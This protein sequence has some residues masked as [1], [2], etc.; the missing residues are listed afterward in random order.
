VR[1][2]FV[3]APS[4]MFESWMWQPA[5]LHNVSAHLRTGD[6]LPDAMVRALIERRKTSSGAFWTRQALLGIY[7][8][9]LHGSPAIPDATALWFDLSRK[10]TAV[11]P[12]PGTFPEAAFIFLMGGYDAGYYGYLW[13][14][15]HALD[16][17]SAVVRAGLEDRETGM[18]FRREV[19]EPGATIEPEEL[20]RSFL[21]RA[22]S[23]EAFY[24]ELGM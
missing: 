14:K 19:L 10:L 4:Q 20:I 1:R 15:V 16:M 9:S 13:S 8:L 12:A 11:P 24:A 3:E 22:P 17:F 2:D 23:A 6:P 18:R 21:G 7:D 5:I